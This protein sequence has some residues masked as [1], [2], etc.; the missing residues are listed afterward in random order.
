MSELGCKHFTAVLSIESV[1][2]QVV[3]FNCSL[4]DFIVHMVLPLLIYFKIRSATVKGEDSGALI[5]KPDE[6]KV[7]EVCHWDVAGEDK[8]LIL[9]SFEACKITNLKSGDLRPSH[10][11]RKWA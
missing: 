3:K 6:S 10:H 5:E 9:L 2:I 1:S 11:H 4:V 7:L 8:V